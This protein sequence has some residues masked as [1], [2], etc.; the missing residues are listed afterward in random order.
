MFSEIVA[1][2]NRTCTH[3]SFI[4]P[5]HTLRGNYQNHVHRCGGIK[6]HSMG[7]KDPPNVPSDL[8]EM[9]HGFMDDGD[10]DSGDYAEGGDLKR[11][12]HLL[13][14][15][16]LGMQERKFREVCQAIDVDPEAAIPVQ[17]APGG[18]T[19][20]RDFQRSFESFGLQRNTG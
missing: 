15:A 11:V 1:P 18:Q 16:P 9:Y 10:G 2:T 7:D 20:F 17:V 5:L 19:Y 13:E 14:D 12:R 8:L 4:F 3:C 6:H